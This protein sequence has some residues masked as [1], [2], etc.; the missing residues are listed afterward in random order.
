MSI[1]NA[2]ITVTETDAVNK[3]SISMARNIL[4]EQYSKP[5]SINNVRVESDYGAGRYDLFGVTIGVGN[6]PGII[7]RL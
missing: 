1:T 5:P 2:D 6:T 4:I 3:V 7:A